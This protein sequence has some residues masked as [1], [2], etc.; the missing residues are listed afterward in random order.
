MDAMDLILARLEEWLAEYGGDTVELAN[1]LC[2]RHAADP[3]RLAAICEDSTGATTRLTFHQLQERSARFAGALQDLEVGQGDRVAV[4]LPKTAELL[5]AVLAI[6]RLGAVYVPLFT[7]F[8]PVAIGYRLQHSNTQVVVTDSANRPKITDTDA[9]ERTIIVVE[10]GDDATVTPHTYGFWQSLRA[11]TPMERSI[12]LSG[13]DPMILIY[14]SG[15]TGHP[16]GVAVP[17]RALAAFQTYMHFGLDVRPDDVFW[18]IADPGWGYGLY[19]GVVGPLLLGQATLL[20]NAP[21]SADLVWRTWET[22]GVTNFAAAPTVFRA[23]RAADA[24]TESRG[25]PRLRIASSAG[26]PL[27]P[28]VVVWAAKVLG[29]PLHDHYGQTEHGMVV[30]NHHH[31]TLRRPVKA[32]SMGHGMPGFHVTILDQNEAELGPGEI[33]QLAIDVE[34]SPL[35]WFD[36]YFRDPEESARRFTADRRFYRSGDSASQDSDGYITFTGRDDDLINSAGYRIGPFE[37]E[38]VLVAHPAVAEAAV[39]GTPDPLRGEAVKAFVVLRPDVMPNDALAEELKRFIKSQLS[40]HAFPREFTFLDTLPKT[41]SGKI[42]RFL[43]RQQTSA[44]PQGNV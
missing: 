4:L 28:D 23:L 42:Q 9:A 35:F 7:A 25:W 17:V 6:W 40:A 18:N 43:L 2:D 37:V 20:V 26:E 38:S 29:G 31:P 34:R 15:T 33:G 12:A 21:F 19:Y 8:G 14:T 30:N 22:Y 13:A 1:L 27:N 39:V 3:D 10:N 41:P 24:A 5:I 11:T 36:G 32:S 44:V 16:K